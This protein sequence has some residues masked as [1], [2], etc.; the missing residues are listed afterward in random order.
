MYYEMNLNKSFDY[1]N[2]FNLEQIE[3]LIKFTNIYL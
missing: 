2:E 1:L 3:I